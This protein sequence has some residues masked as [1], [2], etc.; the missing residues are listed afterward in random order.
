GISGVTQ[1]VIVVLSGMPTAVHTI[2]LA[3]EFEARPNQVTS[4]V[5]LS[6]AAS[7]VTLTLLIWTVQRVL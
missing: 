4:T 5:A 6:T 2:I 7:L 3:T 1:Q